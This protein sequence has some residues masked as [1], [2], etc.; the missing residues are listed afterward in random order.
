M[1]LRNQKQNEVGSQEVTS[2]GWLF[3]YR[4]EESLLNELPSLTRQVSSMLL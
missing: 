3:V 1:K 4:L 2:F